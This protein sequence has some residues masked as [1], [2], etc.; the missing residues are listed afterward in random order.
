MDKGPIKK[1]SVRFFKDSLAD[2]RKFNDRMRHRWSGYDQQYHG[3]NELPE[4][5][6]DMFQD[7]TKTP[8]IWQTVETIKP[9][10]MDPEPRFEFNPVEPSDRHMSDVLQ[11][12]IRQQLKADQFVST[13]RSLVHDAMIY[14]LGVAKVIWNQQITENFEWGIDEDGE[15]VPV[16]KKY[17]TTNRPHIA[18]V[19]PHDFFPD[20]AATNDTNWRYVFHRIWLTKEEL[21]AKQEAGVYKNV[22]KIKDQDNESASRATFETEEEAEVRRGSKIA[23]YEGWFAD[24]RVMTMCGDILLA[25][26]TNPYFHRQIPF[27]AFGTQPNPRSLVGISEVEKLSAIQNTIWI[28]DN[29]KIE[30]DNYAINHVWIMD[31]QIPGAEEGIKL[32]PGLTIPAMNGQRVEQLQFNSNSGPMMEES[33]MQL[34]NLQQIAGSTPLMAGTS[35]DSM[36]IDNSTATGASIMQEEGNKRMAMKKLEFRL[37]CARIAKMMVQLNHQF[38]SPME[39]ERIVGEEGAGWKPIAPQEIP[40][41]LDVL[42]EAMNESLSRDNERNSVLE[43]LNMTAQMQGMPFADG[44]YF[45]QKQIVEDLLKTYDREPSTSFSDTPPPMGEPGEEPENT[46]DSAQ[47]KLFQSI[48]YKDLPNEAQRAMLDAMGMPSEGVE[49]DDAKQTGATG[50]GF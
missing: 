50:G 29:Q 35:P 19:D 42:P 41:F 9:R 12:L 34:A 44:T 48:N 18:Y 20:P 45:D 38:I 40:M 28:K 8:W 21:K 43:L 15:Q 23:I 22:N 49:M 5:S 47:Q 33:Q 17:I 3:E 6:K 10:I 1:K 16:P 36:N 24:G 2:A 11:R 14:G 32:K 30:A 46:I 27:V 4:S 39:I 26:R 31:P 7:V 13:Q 25:E 37:F